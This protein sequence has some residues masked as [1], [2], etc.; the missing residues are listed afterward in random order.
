MKII[1]LQSENFKRLVAVEIT[2]SGNMVEI[3][4]R[5]GQGKTSVLDSIW[6]AL[7]GLEGSPRQPIR[8]GELEARIILS[9]GTDKPELIVTRTF[10]PGKNSDITS[11]LTVE[12]AEGARFPGPQAVLDKLLGALSFDPL[13]FDRMSA[14][15][16]FETL[17]AFV[18]GV[19]FAAIDAANKADYDQ[20][21][22]INRKAKEANAAAATITIDP[23]LAD[24]ALVDE[25]ELTAKLE[26]AG[27]HNTDIE[28]RKANRQRMQ[29]EIG[30]IT[31]AVANMRKHAADLERQAAELKANAQ[32][33]EDDTARK[34]AR[35]DAAGNLAEPIDTKALV[36]EI[37]AA[38]QRNAQ[39]LDHQKRKNARREMLEAAQKAE[40]Q[41]QALTEAMDLREAKK[42]DAI[43][44]AKLPI[45]GVT[46][47]DGE[48]LLGGVP[49]NQASDA[50][51]LRASMAMAM[52]TNPT[53]RIVRVRDGSLLDDDSM[54]LVAEMAEKNDSQVWLE[55]VDSSGRVGIV[56]EDGRVKPTEEQTHE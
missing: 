12:S 51:R 23:T 44:A 56:L 16:Q 6:V 33:Q 28:T 18:P 40:A 31:Q 41:A 52:A 14:K 13:A 7:A 42:R 32:A 29:G 39:V 46:F 35:L 27:K 50:E 19:D 9:L 11:K 53:L 4:G 2:P 47:G 55:R 24:A 10:R 5:N 38:R 25:S 45:D 8:K 21:T 22:A 26:A 49:W 30:A 20:R 15:Q 43:A 37:N 1:K 17:R 36:A 34:Q 3:T 54:K 48:I